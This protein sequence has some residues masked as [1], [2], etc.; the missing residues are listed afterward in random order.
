MEKIN[1]WLIEGAKIVSKIIGK[2]I[3]NLQ[4]LESGPKSLYFWCWVSGAVGFSIN[5]YTEPRS[6]YVNIIDTDGYVMVRY[7][8]G[9]DVEIN[10]EDLEVFEIQK[11][12]GIDRTRYEFYIE[13]EKKVINI[14]RRNIRLDKLEKIRLWINKKNGLEIFV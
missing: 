8:I 9:R 3:E 14:I 13:G 6:A 7:H 10:Y 4:I 11:I 5:Y 1:N 2:E 12:I